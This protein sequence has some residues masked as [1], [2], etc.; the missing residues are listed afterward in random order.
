M[1]WKQ[2][3]S[4]GL[5]LCALL[6]F[7]VGD[8]S[9]VQASSRANMA[10]LLFTAV[11][12]P[13]G[14][15]HDFT[16]DD[17]GLEMGATAVYQSPSL[18]APIPFN[19]VVPQWTTDLPHLELMVRTGTADDQWQEWVTLHS[20]NDWDTTPT[21][22]HFIGEMIS[23][24]APDSTHQ[25]IQFAIHTENPGTIQHLRLTFIDSTSGPTFDEMVSRQTTLN[26]TENQM[27]DSYPKPFV[28]SRE[29]WCEDPACDY[30]EGLTYSPTT[31]L[32]VHHT[33]SDNAVP[34]WPDHLRAIW[35][36]HTFGL[37]W[38]DIG[39]NYLIDPHGNIYEGHLGGDDVA[40][41]HANA[42]NTGSMG[43]A[44]LGDFEFVNPSDPMLN[45]AIELL[46]WKADQRD[47][48]V[49]ES[50]RTLPNIAWGLPTL[51]GHRDVYGGFGTGCPGVAAHTLLPWLRD[52]VAAR[53]GYISPYIYVDELS[54]YFSR[55]ATSWF[56]AENQCGHNLH[57]NYTWT[58]IQPEQSFHWGE[59]QLPVPEDGRYQLEAFIPFCDTGRLETAG[60]KYKIHHVTGDDV[61]VVNQNENVGLWVSLG[62]YDF[63]AGSN[64]RVRL[65]NRTDTDEELGIWFDALRLLPIAPAAV[66][67]P[68]TPT[69]N[70]W[71]T[72][73]AVPFQWHID[74]P[75]NVTATHFEAATDPDFASVVI[76][77]TW[78]TA[79][80]THTHT[81]T[82]SHPDLYW[83][84]HL[85]TASGQS[86]SPTSHFRLDVS[87]PQSAVTGYYWLPNRNQYILTWAG[88]DDASGIAGYN[89]EMRTA[90]TTT[91]QPVITGT[92]QTAVSIS[93]TLSTTDTIWF[94]SQATDAV[95]HLEPLH[96]DPGDLN[97][98]QAISLTHDIMLPIVKR[99]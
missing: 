34:N 55:S 77:D 46:A 97:S 28:I 72:E 94:R 84:V 16:I 42:A 73:T 57:G 40:G 63:E 2:V 92:L 71:L 7:Q 15:G 35:N 76:S 61:V 49:Y 32:I 8:G 96:L 13:Q 70:I 14:T 11:A 37:G 81:F 27:M 26:A 79:V 54:S 60:A 48:N 68:I 43:I 90:Q 19:A 99:N 75:E 65:K 4:I 36:F 20:H 17:G 3:I 41:I 31:H 12:F 87:P 30:S 88:E 82:Q 85:D 23:V 5:I 58:K 98:T 18:Q 59:W 66:A 50:A 38:G 89:I 25:F 47:I 1:Q 6:T 45:S 21:D 22:N 9:Q 83:R 52:E 64:N 53:L 44:L 86:T 56:T 33:K 24:P 10:D 80:L 95:G 51:M 69:T 39:Y 74:H 67:S 62:E 91:W 93:F 78:Q 29:A